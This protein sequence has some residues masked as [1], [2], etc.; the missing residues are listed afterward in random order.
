[1]KRLIAIGASNSKNSI[2]KKFANWAAHRVN[3]V[4]VELIDLNDYETPLYSS[5]LEKVEGIPKIIEELKNK[6]DSAN[7]FVISLAEHNGNYTVAF[8]N[9]QDWL[10]RVEMKIWG[11][12]PTF[13]MAA[14]PGK[15][16]GKSVLNIA[17]SSFP[18][19][20]ANV[21]SDYS[22]PEFYKNFND[23]DGITNSTLLKA[24]NDS[25][26]TFSKQL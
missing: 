3:D 25:L 10:S 8:K 11:D 9:I 24:F 26:E 14:T 5:D 1:M 18:Y 7:G 4:Q 17:K 15:M 19:M 23:S 6:L 20:G 13:L 2:N 16:G 12:K 22:L 21:V